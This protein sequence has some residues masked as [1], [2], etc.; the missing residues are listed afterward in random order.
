MKKL[1]VCLGVLFFY[2]PSAFSAN[3]ITGYV[4]TYPPISPQPGFF[5]ISSGTVGQLTDTGLSGGGCVQAAP[6]GLFTTT[7]L[8]CGSGSAGS[9][10]GSVN[11]A[12]QYSSAYYSGVST[13]II[14]GLTPGT[15]GQILTTAGPSAAPFWATPVSTITAASLGALTTSSATA[16]YLQIIA[17]QQTYFPY[18]GGV[19][20]GPIDSPFG[21]FQNGYQVLS[22]TNST[23]NT[24]V[25]PGALATISNSG[26]SDTAV[27]MNALNANLTGSQNTGIGAGALSADNTGIQ[28]TA[29]GANALQSVT[30][31]QGN[32]ALGYAALENTNANFN[33]AVGAQAL[34]N[35]TSGTLNNALGFQAL[36][37]NTTATNNTGIGEGALGSTNSGSGNTAV[38]N[39]AGSNNTTGTNNLFLGLNSNAGSNNLTNATAIGANS[40]VGTSNTMQLGGTGTNAVNVIGSTFTASEYCYAGIGCQTSPGGGGSSSLAVFVNGVLISTPTGILGFNG[41]GV[42]STNS[43]SSTTITIAGSGGGGGNNSSTSTVVA[44]YGLSQN[45]SGST[46]TLSLLG[47]TSSYIQNTN[48]LQSGSTFYVSSGTVAGQFTTQSEIV[49]GPGNG[50]IVLTINGST[51]TAISSSGTPVAGNFLVVTSTNFTVGFSTGTGGS[52]GGSGSFT[53]I[54]ASGQPLLTSSATFVSG[55]NITLTQ[56]GSSITIAG[57]GGGTPGGADTQVQYDS[58]GVFA[59]TSLETFTPSSSPTVVNFN[60]ISSVTYNNFTGITM[61][62]GTILEIDNMGT[63]TPMLYFSDLTGGLFDDTKAIVFGTPF[64]DYGYWGYTSATNAGGN[65]Y[66]TNSLTGHKVWGFNGQNDS[67]GI[68]PG[69]V[70]TSNTPTLDVTGN[71]A[72]GVPSTSAASSQLA[73]VSTGPYTYALAIATGTAL[74]PFVTVSTTS[75]RMEI[76]VF[77][78][79]NSTAFILRS[80]NGSGVAP[81][82][83]IIPGDGTGILSVQVSSSGPGLIESRNS[84]QLILSSQLGNPTNAFLSEI[85]I[86]SA[87]GAQVVVST[88]STYE[89]TFSTGP[90][91]IASNGNYVVTAP[92]ALDISTTGHINGQ[93]SAPVPSACGTSPSMAAGSNDWHGTINVGS[94]VVTACTLTFSTPFK[95]NPPDCVVSDNSAT[96]SS[97]VTAR[98][99]TAITL[100]SSATIAGGTISYICVGSD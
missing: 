50:N 78:P 45:I 49:N 87:S 43:G 80:Q 58:A 70:A 62:T 21:Y 92:Y 6:G 44:G 23:A 25:G 19:L 38:G 91:V 98:S 75:G 11:P 59:G 65:V 41:S 13:T 14:S 36:F 56:V 61:G 76:T 67:T 34:N 85:I 8:G 5:N 10:N 33:T 96:V 74:A 82:M 81:Q 37:R 89:A 15:S 32:S 64:G 66:F 86:S 27:G 31:W 79:S 48:S 7:G 2:V 51:Y 30:V 40:S 9:T 35:N 42:T 20:T 97:G 90:A 95:T 72:I 84:N 55:A 26:T 53:S 77:G 94:G 29:V 12:S 57:T 73:I 47:N 22:A 4:Q 39:N 16:T 93:G 17:A 3:P 52:G 18:S 1:L 83:S 46:I 71:M 24:A 88:S 28:N 69:Y 60:N 100:G 54:A 68:G 99:A 63:T